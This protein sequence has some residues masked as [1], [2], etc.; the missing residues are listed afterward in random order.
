LL[1]APKANNKFQ[2]RLAGAAGKSQKSI[3]KYQNDF[4]N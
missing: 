1:K 2:T 4:V 3:S